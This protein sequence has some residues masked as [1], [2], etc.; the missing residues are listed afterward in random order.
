MCR[1]SVLKGLEMPGK[2][3]AIQIQV[4]GQRI[5]GTSRQYINQLIAISPPRISGSLDERLAVLHSLGVGP[6]ADESD[7]SRTTPSRLASAAGFIHLEYQRKNPSWACT[8]I[9]D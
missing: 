9:F 3:S 1:A 8:D 2:Q 4:R 7:I 5:Q 6:R